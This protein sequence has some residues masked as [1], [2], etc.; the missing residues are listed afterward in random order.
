MNIRYSTAYLKSQ[1]LESSDNIL[2][3]HDYERSTGKLGNETNNLYVQYDKIIVFPDYQYVQRLRHT[4]I[5]R[6]RYNQ[7]PFT[8]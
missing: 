2:V 6:K 7:K 8:K 5:R 4:Q 3:F 1:V